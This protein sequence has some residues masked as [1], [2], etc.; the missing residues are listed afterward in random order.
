MADADGDVTVTER[1]LILQYSP[2]GRD[3]GH[4]VG[5]QLL[6][7]LYLVRHRP[8]DMQVSSGRWKLSLSNF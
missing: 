2:P 1:W 5:G 6:R 8:V 3:G 4:G 7:M